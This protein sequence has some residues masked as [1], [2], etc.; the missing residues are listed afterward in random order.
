MKYIVNVRDADGLISMLGVDQHGVLTGA[1]LRRR[2]ISVE[3]IRH[4]VAVGRLTR[5]KPDIYRL[6]DHPWTWE[7]Q[8]Q[9]GLFDVGPGALLSHRSAAQL[10]GLWRYRGQN[11]VEITEKEQHDHRVTLARLHRS[12]HV[13]S[14]HRTVIRGFP[15][16]T[17]ARTCF[18]LFGDPDPGLR[19]TT[20]GRELHA[21]LMM[22][23]LNDALA[24]RGLT[25]GQLT[26]VL[27]T[28][29]KRGRPGTALARELL[30]RLAPQYVPTE[31]DGESL[32]IELVE[33]L[34][35]EPPE[36]QV[37]LTDDEGWIGTVDFLW[38]RSAFVLE[39]DGQW[40]DGPLDQRADSER[41][42]RIEAL[43]LKVRRVKYRDVVADP[44]TF[45]RQLRVDCGAIAPQS[46]Q[47]STSGDEDWVS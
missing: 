23:V 39:M 18:D 27:A 4:R 46:I 47:H 33:A 44:G 9:A 2:G 7:A 38:R 35:L 19:H 16:T 17:V 36:R 1:Q 6:T 20:E 11:A 32:V 37:M 45:T 31:S 30:D 21:T 3:A 10:H 26:N 29:G 12:A 28:I 42:R 40:H 22:R 34:G 24:R 25:L 5:L 8:L 43:G 14:V 15:V 13:P 41:D